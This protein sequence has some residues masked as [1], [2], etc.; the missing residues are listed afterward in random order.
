MNDKKLK[1]KN[2][3]IETGEFGPI[4]RQFEGKPKEAIIFLKNRKQANVLKRCI[5]MIL[6]MSI[7]YGVLAAKADMVYAILLNNMKMS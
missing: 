4:Y 1:S 2:A 5:V 3:Q 7:S 6:D